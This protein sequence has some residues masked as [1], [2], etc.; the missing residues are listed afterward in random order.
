MR[1]EHRR[2]DWSR[3]EKTCLECY[4]KHMNA[5]F[6]L[7][8][9]NRTIIEDVL[10]TATVSISDL[11]KNPGA[12]VAEAVLRQVAILN[13]NRPVAYVVAPHVWEYLCDLVEDMKDAE[14]VRE[15]LE[16]PGEVIT[17]SIDD[18]V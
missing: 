8:V 14:I 2:R 16:N 1:Q 18:L 13:R 3:L 17:I 7:P 5:P 15:R 11:K 6:K 4:S 12:V 9:V 10:A